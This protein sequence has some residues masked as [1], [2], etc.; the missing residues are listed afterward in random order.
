MMNS[1]LKLLGIAFFIV[2]SLLNYY[3]GLRSFQAIK[4]FFPSFPGI[5]FWPVLA[6]VTSAYII[7]RALNLN[8][9][10]LRL[11][12]S[13]WI[14]AFFY[15]LLI[16]ILLDVGLY[17]S[18]TFHIFSSSGFSPDKKI[19]GAAIVITSII[20]IIGTW[21]ARNLQLVKYDLHIAKQPGFDKLIIVLI[22]DLHVEPFASTGYMEKA[23]DTITAQNPDLIFLAGDIV[24]GS[25][26]P[27]TESKL[28]NILSKMKAKYGIFAVLGNHEYYGG[29]ADQISAF[30]EAKGVH[31]LR[32]EMY[33]A[34]DGKVIIAGRNSGSGPGAK[35]SRKSLQE[36][37]RGIDLSKPLIVLDH[38]PQAV[39][40]AQKS[41]ADLLLSGHTHGGQLF[42]LQFFTKSLFIIDRGLWQEE[43]FHLIVSTGLGIWGPPIRTSAR[44]EVV[45]AILHFSP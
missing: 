23:A 14:A 17:I 30:L 29:Q 31:V 11:I 27:Q 21:F 5:V 4:A 20:L 10:L 32:D 3:V 1:S 18:S 42:P 16:F 15:L 38:Q 41:G 45:E 37:I 9:Y 13:Y 40:E 44:A 24:E 7:D 25:L 6:V 8:I 22:S 39:S 35:D 43:S 19:Y 33:T 34:G 2:Y 36:I 28:E 12:G 26:N